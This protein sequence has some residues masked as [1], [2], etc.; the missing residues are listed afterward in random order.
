MKNGPAIPPALAAVIVII[1]L[2][3]VGFFALKG[4][5]VVGG[6]TDSGMTQL[7]KADPTSLSQSQIDDIKKNMDAARA[8]RGATSN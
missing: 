3:V 4:T 6:K 2:V 7:N 8:Q 5:G 1:V